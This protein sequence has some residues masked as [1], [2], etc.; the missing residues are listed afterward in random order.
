MP[1]EEH[2]VSEA[3]H[4]AGIQAGFVRSSVFSEVDRYF[5]VCIVLN[6]KTPFLNFAH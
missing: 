3:H 2:T 1:C 5:L 4:H 6:V